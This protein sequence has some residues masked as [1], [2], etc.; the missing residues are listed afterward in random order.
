VDVAIVKV[1]DGKN[2]SKVN[3]EGSGPKLKHVTAAPLLDDM[4]RD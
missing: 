4:F 2:W 3:T 1:R